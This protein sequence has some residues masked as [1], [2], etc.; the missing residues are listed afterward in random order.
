MSNYF[1]SYWW[2]LLTALIIWSVVWKGLGLWRAA[3]NGSKV[4]FAVMLV[5]NTAGILEMV[6]YFWLGRKQ[7]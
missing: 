7:S 1:S 2:L 3:R 4:W 6:Y 5:L